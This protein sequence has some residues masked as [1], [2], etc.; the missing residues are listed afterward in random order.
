MNKQMRQ[1]AGNLL[2]FGY[3]DFFGKVPSRRFRSLCLA[4][5]LGRYGN[6]AAVQMN[7]RFLNGRRIFLGDR[8]I[9]NFGCLLDGRK[10]EIRTGDDVSIGPE[11]AILTLG[12]DPNSPNFEDRGGPITIGSHAWIAYRAIVL[13]GVTIGEGAVVAAGAVVSKDVPAFAVVAGNP[14]RMVRQRNCD[15]TYRLRHAPFLR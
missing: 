6:G 7:C 15:L 3:N 8:T 12:H 13:P 5:C 2:S 9:I 10:Y 1:L 14:A 11:A 4:W